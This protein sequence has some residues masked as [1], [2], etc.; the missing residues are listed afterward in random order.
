M[1]IWALV[2]YFVGLAKVHQTSKTRV[3]FALLVPLVLAGLFIT[4]FVLLHIVMHAMDLLEAI[5]HTI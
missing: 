3:F 5:Q 2:L 4:G 1:V